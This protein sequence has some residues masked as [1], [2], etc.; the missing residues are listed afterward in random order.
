[1]RTVTF[2]LLMTLAVGLA[3]QTD[4]T[5]TYQG[6]LQ[7]VDGP[8][9]GTPG[10][11]F[12][13]YDSLTGGAQV[14]TEIILSAVEVNDGLFQV[15]LDFGDV[16]DGSPVYLEVMVAGHTL[17]PRQL[18]S[19]TPM[20]ISALNLGS[21]G[22]ADLD[23]RY[24]KQ[25]GNGST[26]PSL[27]FLGTTDA[28]AFVV[29]IDDKEILRAIPAQDATFGFSPNIVVGAPG[30]LVEAAVFGAVIGGGG[31]DAVPN[32]VGA[33][34]ATVSG[35]F[36]NTASGFRATVGGGANNT[37]SG[38]AA[39]VGGG[40][41][42]TASGDQSTVPGG[43][44][45]RA[46]GRYSLA[47]GS[48]ATANHDGTFVWS[49]STVTTADAFVST[50]ENQ[51][52]INAQNGVGINHASPTNPLH[53]KGTD[54][55]VPTD[56]AAHV[57]L[58]EGTDDDAS[59]QI[60]AV[61]SGYSGTPTSENKFITFFGGNNNVVGAIEGNGSGGVSLSTSGADFAE[62]LP[63]RSVDEVI[64]PAEVVGLH[65]DGV[66]K[67]TDGARRIMVVSSYP[68]VKGNVPGSDVSRHEL[69]AFMGQVPVRVRGPVSVGDFLIPSGMSDGTAIAA[70]DSEIAGVALS[71]VIG[72]VLEASEESGIGEVNALVGLPQGGVTEAVV[73]DLRQR[74]AALEAE[75]A[76]LRSLADQSVEFQSRLNALE[77]MLLEGQHS[78][79]TSQ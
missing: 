29:R 60:L 28:T 20:A 70:H 72:R 41:D 21:A 38:S 49:D 1:M 27:D 14:G 39:S 46:S 47:A 18:I 33:S 74:V 64:A 67:Q 78:V 58:I 34:F 55:G 11:E 51:F 44:R 13:L 19:A 61:K 17:E 42:G 66:S 71:R 59:N 45:N 76:R 24:W 30:N 5:I 35:G 56:P 25:G 63:R 8:F 7:D 10:M 9:T 73:S 75:N 48:G 32:T 23:D 52:L 77:A 53:V 79:A 37:A 43:F 68:L 15:E 6:Q 54:T 65:D 57:A 31:A 50:D 2:I 36:D 40:A 4:T 12:R 16:F 62:Y 22:M 69:V 26:S 3:A